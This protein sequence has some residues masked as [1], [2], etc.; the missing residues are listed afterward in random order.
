MTISGTGRLLAEG[1]DVA[2]IRFTRQP[3]GGNWGS[4]DFLNET[5]ESRLAYADFDFCGGTTIGGHNAEVHVNNAIV[6]FD[7]LSFASTPVVQYISF[8]NSSFHRPELHLSNISR[9]NRP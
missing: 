3:G 1:T 6:F 7:H 2:H 9:H 8:D 4:L 5:V